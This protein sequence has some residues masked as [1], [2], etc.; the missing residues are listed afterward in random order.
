MILYSDA[1]IVVVDKP[2]GM[3]VHRS[4]L[5]NDGDVYLI[6]VVRELVDG[7]LHLIHRLDRATS[8]VLLIG[9]SSE[10]AATLGRQFMQRDVEKTYLAV[11]RGWPEE[12]GEIDY[13]LPGVREKSERKPA[14]TRWQRLATT[15][16]PIPINRYPQ[17][18]YALLEV[19]PETGRYR[20]IRRHFAHLRHPLIGDTSH[21]RTEHNRLF[22]Q[23][24]GVHRL[25]LHA[26]RLAFDHPLDG[27][28]LAV[29][30]ALDSEFAGVLERFEWALPDIRAVAGMPIGT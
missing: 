12:T 27:R 29:E 20:Q 4:R 30:A 24:F 9:R 13:A 26:W 7:P 1:H 19:S 5:V 6:D 11:C 21:G 15:E 17:Q 18:R 25:L 10:I 16:V 14:L 22:K 23:H 3:P 8:G 28:R 2:A